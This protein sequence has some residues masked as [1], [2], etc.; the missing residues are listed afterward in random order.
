MR[1][2]DI[3]CK[4]ALKFVSTLVE[5]YSFLVSQQVTRK[6]SE[7]LFN[8]IYCVFVCMLCSSLQTHR[9]LKP[10]LDENKHLMTMASYC[11]TLKAIFRRKL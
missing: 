3:S 9:L 7:G 1:G 11:R 4:G 5:I 8:K 6:R 10:Y 2:I